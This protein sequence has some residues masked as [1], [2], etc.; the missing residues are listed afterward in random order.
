MIAKITFRLLSLATLWGLPCPQKSVVN[1][2]RE[3]QVKC[4]IS[5][6]K[7]LVMFWLEGMSPILMTATSPPGALDRWML[8]SQMIHA[9]L[10]TQIIRN[11]A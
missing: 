10:E 8:S 11:L 5:D 7:N 1:I 9:E 2:L 3:I 6:V 4:E